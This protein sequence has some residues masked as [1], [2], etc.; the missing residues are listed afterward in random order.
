MNET[1]PIR[2]RKLAP[3]GMTGEVVADV[4]DIEDTLSTCIGE[5]SKAFFQNRR[6]RRGFNGAEKCREA[7][8]RALQ[9]SGHSERRHER[10]VNKGPKK[11]LSGLS[12]RAID[13]SAAHRLPGTERA[14]GDRNARRRGKRQFPPTFV[15]RS[16]IVSGWI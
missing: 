2:S 10:L 4:Y 15:R 11:R 1:R 6:S 13:Q 7:G 12:T 14:H 5:I 16:R 3:F 8:G 9:I